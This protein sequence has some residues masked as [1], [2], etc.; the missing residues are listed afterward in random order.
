MFPRLD[1]EQYPIRDD[2]RFV[3]ELLRAQHVLVVQGTGFNWPV[4]D[5]LR[6]V[7]LPRADDLT[8]AIGRLGDFLSTVTSG[9]LLTGLADRILGGAAAGQHHAG[10]PVRPAARGAGTVCS[11]SSTRWPGNARR[12][13]GDTEPEKEAWVSDTLLEWGSCGQFAYVDGVPAGYV[14]YAPPAYVPRA[15]AFPTSPVSADAVL[16]MTRC[17]DAGVRAAAGWAGCWSRAW[18]GMSCAAACARSRRSAAPRDARRPGRRAPTTAACCRRT[19]CSRSGSRPSAR[20]RARRGCA[21]TSK[22]TVT[23]KEDVE[24]ALERLLSSMQA[25]VLSR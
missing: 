14:L 11:G 3:L 22:T 12:D 8:D 15:V 7:T 5:H 23:W 2:Q 10:Q 9:D 25:P 24:Y 17:A 13:R 18:R 21:W 19:T 1:P 6:I 20:T 16:L 4:P